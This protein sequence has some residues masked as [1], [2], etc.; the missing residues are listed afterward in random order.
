MLTMCYE[1]LGKKIK[2]DYIQNKIDEVNKALCQ[3][4]YECALTLTMTLPDICAKVAYKNNKKFYDE[5]G[6]WLTAKSYKQWFQNYVFNYFNN[7]SIMLNE[8]KKYGFSGEHL[9]FTAEYCYHLRCALLHEG[10]IEDI[11]FKKNSD[12]IIYLFGLTELSTCMLEQVYSNKKVAVKGI[13]INIKELCYKI[14]MGVEKFYMEVDP[15]RFKK[16]EFKIHR[17]DNSLDLFSR[18]KSEDLD[19]NNNL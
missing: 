17:F 1:N 6:C 14:I 9:K 12:G 8:N 7:D 19:I 3:G 13:E 10:N 15:K 2:M 5:K 16:Y 18:I 4:L 11:A